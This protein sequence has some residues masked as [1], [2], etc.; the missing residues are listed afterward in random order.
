MTRDAGRRK[1]ATSNTFFSAPLLFP[2]TSSSV[3]YMMAEK[4]MLNLMS[5]SIHLRAHTGRCVC[6]V[7]RKTG[8]LINS[9]YSAGNLTKKIRT[10]SELV[11]TGDF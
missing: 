8:V 3:I 7:A 9:G 2:F 4:N 11:T 6:V 10:L 1:Q 5:E